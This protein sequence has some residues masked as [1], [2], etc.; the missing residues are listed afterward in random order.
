MPGEH[1]QLSTRGIPEAYRSAVVGCGDHLIIVRKAAAIYFHV[2]SGDDPRLSLGGYVQQADF[3]I[4]GC[5]EE[6]LTGRR[7]TAPGCFGGAAVEGPQLSAL[8]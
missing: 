3:P 7:V 8:A 2:G 4:P 6:V 5:Q 1:L